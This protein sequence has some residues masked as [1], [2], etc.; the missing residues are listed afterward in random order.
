MNSLLR[1]RCSLINHTQFQAKIIQNHSSF[2]AA[3]T[4]IGYT[5]EYPQGIR[6]SYSLKLMIY[7]MLAK[8]LLSLLYI[9]TALRSQKTRL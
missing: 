2:G 4:Y 5:R 7:F 9:E 6:K 8:N 3:H 1:Y